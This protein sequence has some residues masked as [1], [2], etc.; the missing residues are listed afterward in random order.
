VTAL[1]AAAALSSATTGP[2]TIAVIQVQFEDEEPEPL[3]VESARTMLFTGAESLDAFYQAETG[4][5]VSFSGIEHPDGDFFGSY[6]LPGDKEN[7]TD[8]PVEIAKQE[9]EDDGAPLEDYDHLLFVFP[10][11]NNCFNNVSN[12]AWAERQGRI[13]GYNGIPD[14]YYIF[15]HEIGHNLGV[16]HANMIDCHDN[17]G[18]QVAVSD[19]CGVLEYGDPFDVMGHNLLPHNVYFLDSFNLG[20]VAEAQIQT[21]THAGTF[22]IEPQVDPD[23]KV[24]ML[25]VP[26]IRDF[27]GGVASWYVLELRAPILPF[28]GEDAATSG[29]SIRSVVRGEVGGPTLL[30]DAQPGE[31][32]FGVDP[33]ADAPLPVGHSFDD[34]VVRI[35]AEAIV[36]G[37]SAVV[38]IA[39]SHTGDPVPPSAPTFLSGEVHGGTADLEWAGASDNFYVA[40]CIVLRDGAQIASVPC[41]SPCCRVT[42]SDPDIPLGPHTYTVYAVDEAGNEGP[43]SQPLVL[44][45]HDVTPPT[46]PQDA[47]ATVVDDE[48]ALRWS[49]SSDDTGISGYWISRDGHPVG[50][51]AATNF[52]EAGLAPGTYQFKVR[53]RDVAGNFSRPAVVSA[54]V[55][56]GSG[57][58]ANPMATPQPPPPAPAV[59]KPA[60]APLVVTLVWHKGRDR[61]IVFD[62]SV[63]GGEGRKELELFTGRRRI[64]ARA[65]DSLR[66]VWSPPRFRRRVHVVAKATDVAG[67]KAATSRWLPLGPR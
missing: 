23:A 66:A 42:F 7:C 55:E 65:A 64:A 43:P 54:V 53:A 58:A 62:A 52:S 21:V 45:G 15:A 59:S 51:T 48:V 50:S 41:E 16:G 26:A 34:G 10:P 3:P 25:R 5:R 38:S 29:V 32:P 6:V 28:E 44:T 22:T 31:T 35:E 40:S 56:D 61:M 20:L 37:Q 14:D 11:G 39:F 2:R 4:G 63:Q 36:P 12:I 13:S 19:R 47:T 57:S 27:D 60:S 33:Y 8:E 67:A 17:D 24:T 9:A 18:A 49:A 30:Y 46:A 1:K